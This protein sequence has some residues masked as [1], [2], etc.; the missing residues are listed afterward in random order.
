MTSDRVVAD[1]ECFLQQRGDLLLRT[2]VLLAGSREGGE[3]LLQDA[4]ERVL[5]RWHRIEGS[6]EGYLRQTLYHLA[7]DGWRRQRRWRGLLPLLQAG[8]RH[9]PL[10]DGAGQVDLHDAII[11]LLRQLPARQRAVLVAR[12]WEDRSEAETA[13]ALGCTVGTVKSAASRGLAR[14]RELSESWDGM[15]HHTTSGRTS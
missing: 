12:Y 2:A 10:V 11:G 6:P 1:L 13:E 14:L 3:D 15:E 5:R 9:Q 8:E 4:L 7:A